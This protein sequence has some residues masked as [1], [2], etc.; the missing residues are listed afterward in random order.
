MPEIV[1]S[2]TNTFDKYVQVTKCIDEIVIEVEK[3]KK[4]NEQKSHDNNEIKDEIKSL[5]EQAEKLDEERKKLR[6]D[7]NASM[8]NRET[9]RHFQGHCRGY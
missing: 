4:D 2:A 8:D 7:L 1:L 5:Q 6:S 9:G 3:L